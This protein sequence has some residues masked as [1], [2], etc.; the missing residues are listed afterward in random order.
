MRDRAQVDEV[1]AA[2]ARA[3]RLHRPAR[4]QR[5]RPGRGTFVSTSPGDDRARA[6][7]ELPRRR[8]VRAGVLAWAA[9]RGGGRRRAHRER[10]LRRGDDRVRAGRPVRGARSTRSSRSPARSPRR[11]AR[12]DPGAHPLAGVRRDGGL[13]STHERCEAVS[14]ADSCSSSDDVARAIVKAVEKGTQGDD[15]ALV[16][17]PP[18][19]DL[20]G[21]LP[22][23]PR[24]ARR[25]LRLPAGH[26]ATSCPSIARLAGDVPADLDLVR[27]G[28]RR[29]AD[30]AALFLVEPAQLEALLEIDAARA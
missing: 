19:L 4:Q 5:G 26:A 9:K 16:P 22:R 17:V 10:R 3:A 27:V 18:G 1:A 28:R 7:D 15:C 13:H 2:R 6:R 30:R 11:C 20:P 24:A 21:A 29:A 14:C 25:E 23:H 8:L 12:G